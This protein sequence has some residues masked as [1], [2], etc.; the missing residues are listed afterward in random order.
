MWKDAFDWEIWI[1]IWIFEIRIKGREICK[2]ISTL[3]NL[4]LDSPFFRTRGGLRTYE[5]GFELFSTTAVSQAH[6]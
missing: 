4:S 3:I 2:P 6:A 1:W 5:K